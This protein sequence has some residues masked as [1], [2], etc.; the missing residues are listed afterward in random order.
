MADAVNLL[1]TEGP[2]T[3]RTG[4]VVEADCLAGGNTREGTFL[5]GIAGLDAVINAIKAKRF[6]RGDPIRRRLDPAGKI[7]SAIASCFRRRLLKECGDGRGQAQEER[8]GPMENN[9]DGSCDYT[10]KIER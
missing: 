7:G 10:I 8:G 6:Y 5:D 1:E 3:E 4:R 9:H 2:V